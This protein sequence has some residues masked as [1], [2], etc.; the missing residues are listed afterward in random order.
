VVAKVRAANGEAG[1]GE[2]CAA[3]AVQPLRAPPAPSALQ[4]QQQQQQRS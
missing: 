3:L 2:F 1:C 4:Q